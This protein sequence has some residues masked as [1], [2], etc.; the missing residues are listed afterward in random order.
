MN[1][2][3]DVHAHLDHALFKKD[4]GEVIQRAEQ[5]G[6]KAIITNG[7]NRPSN[8]NALALAKK[9]PIVKAA[10]GFYPI[11]LLGFGPDEA[12][13]PVQKGPI[14]LDEEL[15]F[16]KKNKDN[17]VAIGEVGMD[18]HWDKEQHKKQEE[19]FHQIIE[20]ASKL[21]KPLIIHSRKAEA[22]VV[23]ILETQSA[24]KVI[25]HCFSGKKSLV[26]KG[27]DLNLNF[28]I[29]ANVERSQSFQMIV[30][31]TPM[32]NL[33]TETDAP[34]LGPNRDERNEPKNVA[35]TVKKIAELKKLDEKEAAL[36]IFKKYKELF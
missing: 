19:N 11:D 9:Y 34:W 17:V 26:K 21:K 20:F 6:V 1:P 23:E 10:L 27:L 13:M 3:V 33:L 35:L 22:K 24:K 31:L 12:G 32:D 28:S 15:D 4:L 18:F 36:L 16:I 14:N 7:T 2:L 30:N 29:P 8:E 25:M 5:A